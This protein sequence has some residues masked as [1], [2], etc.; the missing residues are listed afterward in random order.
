MSAPSP[1]PAEQLANPDHVDIAQSIHEELIA[2]SV[3]LNSGL[4]T[5]EDTQQFE[6]WRALSPAHEA[7]WQKLYAVEQNLR[8]L[9]AEA[10]HMA[11]ETLQIADKQRNRPTTR[12]RTFKLIS[13]TIITLMGAALVANQYAPWQQSLHYATSV[14]KTENFLL[15]DGTQ[16]M[17]NTN[18]KVEIKLSLLKREIVLQRGEI[19]I[20]TGKDSDSIIGRRSFWVKT[21]QAELEAIG[22]RFSV[23]QQSSST[24]LHV[25]DGIVAMHVDNDVPPVRAYANETYTMPDAVSAPIKMGTTDDGLHMD[26]MAWVNGML[27]VKQMRLDEFAIELS[28]Y[29]NLPVVCEP[30]ASNLKVSGVFQLNRADPVEYALKA[31]SRT[32]PVRMRKQDDIIF[33]SKK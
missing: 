21:E 24:K 31:I 33:I 32:L 27:V 12:N 16:L 20:E 28:R 22:T 10:K 13:L 14:G 8:T 17:L 29:Q 11:V 18:S 4:F 6:H 1:S 23:N 2:W 30:S 7:A 5:A 15:A 26:P 3:K 25:V 19:Y 9:P